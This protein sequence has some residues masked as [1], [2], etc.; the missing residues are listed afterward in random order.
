MCI[1]LLLCGY[2]APVAYNLVQTINLGFTVTI[3]DSTTN[4]GIHQPGRG[5]VIQTWY[6][7]PCCSTVS[8][9][10][11]YEELNEVILEDWTLRLS[12]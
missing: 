9:V 3:Y 5:V 8:Y 7:W 2:A 12:R 11:T 6:K 10:F 1:N 4:P